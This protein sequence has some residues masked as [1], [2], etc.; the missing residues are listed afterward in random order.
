MNFLRYNYSNTRVAKEIKDEIADMCDEERE[1]VQELEN[2]KKSELSEKTFLLEN[3]IY[4]AGVIKKRGAENESFLWRNDDIVSKNFP[5]FSAQILEDIIS[6]VAMA[7][8]KEIERLN[9]AFLPKKDDKKELYE[10]IMATVAKQV[11]KALD[12]DFK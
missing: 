8:A 11:K 1:F 9:E 2:L 6:K 5:Y 10:S 4:M 3:I 7:D 12:E